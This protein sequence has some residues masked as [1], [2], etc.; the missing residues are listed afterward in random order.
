MRVRHRPHSSFIASVHDVRADSGDQLLPL[1]NIVFLI[2]IFL[3]ALSAVTTP[4]PFAVEPLRG[5]G[6]SA[7]T[8]AAQ[9]LALS[10]TGELAFNGKRYTIEGLI[11]TLQRPSPAP[12]AGITI[13][14][15]AQVGALQAVRIIEQL[16]RADL[17]EIQLLVKPAR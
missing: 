15:D 16:K 10:A 11:D 12:T 1:I 14:A 6:D 4:P 3:M 7:P 8:Q 9:A 5:Q 13:E 2:L 17:G